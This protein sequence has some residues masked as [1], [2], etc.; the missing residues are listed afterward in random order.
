VKN[1]RRHDRTV[2]VLP[3]PASVV[4]LLSEISPCVRELNVSMGYPIAMSAL[5][6][7]F[8]C[9]VNAQGS[10]REDGY[11]AA[12]YLA[13]LT[14]P[15]LKTMK[16]ALEPAV[17]R[18]LAH[19]VEE[20]LSGAEDTQLSGSIFVK[21]DDIEGFG[22]LHRLAAETLSQ[23]GI[24][25]DAGEVR[26]VLREV[27]EIA[28]GMWERIG[29][30]EDFAQ[31][32]ERFLRALVERGSL[33][34]HFIN[35]RVVDKLLAVSD[36]LGGASFRGERF[37]PEEM[38]RVFMDAVRREKLSFTGSP[39]KGLQV[40]GLFETRSLTFDH[41]IVM[42][43]NESVLPRVRA[44]EPLVPRE[45]MVNLGVNRMEEEEEIQRYH[46]MRLIAHAKDVYLV[47]D[48]DPE[49]GRSRFIEELVWEREKA[50]GTPGEGLV[51][52]AAF[53]TR[54]A[55]KR[56]S[57]AKSARVIDLL[58]EMT[59]SPSRVD[60]YLRCP[61]SFYFHHVL[62]L[63]EKEDL[64]EDPEGGDVG[65]FIHR[66]LQEGFERFRGAQPQVNAEFRGW[67]LREFERAFAERFGRRMKS[68]AFL[69]EHVVRFR[70]E[71]FLDR[72]AE[73]PVEELLALEESLA[74]EIAIGGRS[75]PFRCRIDRIDRVAGGRIMVIDYKTGSVADAPRPR[76]LLGG[77]MLSR[78]WI[79]RAVRSFQLP[80]YR[81]FVGERYE[82]ADASAA[83]YDLRA[84]KL[85]QF[86]ADKDYQH[87]DEIMGACMRA[88]G[89]IVEEIMDPGRPFMADESDPRRCGRC[90]Y[91]RLCR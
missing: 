90:P 64:L 67:F 12:H 49:K 46:F 21:L 6:G 17:T 36:E 74:G 89:Y 44:C 50:R 88:L 68:G 45:V 15:L 16:F 38:F 51:R 62:R 70:L 84:A 9:V 34:S 72:E 28:F 54:L 60:M 57:A 2:I 27:H 47:Y 8:T 76:L 4:P 5:C 26:A 63:R 65:E 66:V 56:G 14:H 53:H 10:R 18:V 24:E 83:L 48:G 42:D 78:E 31:A 82:G 81:H 19:K 75:V 25:L 23:M 13:V 61:L 22:P 91:F 43:V 58:K 86:P 52:R 59:Y 73:R 1:I 35:L 87:A 55:P 7:L 77:G 79:G 30:F 40:L 29:T 37:T 32:L 33:G 20:V 41:V 11:Y 3:E 69:L 71:Q 80:L 39:L 85:I